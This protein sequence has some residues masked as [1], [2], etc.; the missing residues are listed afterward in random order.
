MSENII[1]ELKAVTELLAEGSKGPEID[2]KALYERLTTALADVALHIEK[3]RTNLMDVRP[4]LIDSSESLPQTSGHL[5]D[6]DKTLAD[7]ADILLQITERAIDDNEK[8]STLLSNIQDKVGSGDSVAASSINELISMNTESKGQLMEVLANLSFQDLA[9]QKIKKVNTLIE[10][11]ET[12]ILKILVV[13]G[14]TR[15]GDAVKKE[16]ILS[17]LEGSGGKLN[18]NLVDDILKDF[19]L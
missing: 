15:G 19:G 1:D 17:E 14:Y 6:I 2:Y 11:V 13:L 8:S 9:G 3:V 10:E 7:A 16:E 18:Q 12:R 4:G 5:G